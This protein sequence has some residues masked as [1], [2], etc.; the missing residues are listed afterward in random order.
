MVTGTDANGCQ[1]MVTE[2]ININMNP[3]TPNFATTDVLVCENENNVTYILAGTYTAYDWTIAG[4]TVSSGGTASDNTV[5]V[6]WG[7]NG[8]G[9]VAVIVTDTNGCQANATENITIEVCCGPNC[10]DF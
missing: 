5:T 3:A 8:I 2:N 4:G 1:G 10:G 7:T 9:S 6:N